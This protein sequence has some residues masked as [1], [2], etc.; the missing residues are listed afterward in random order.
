MQGRQEDVQV[1]SGLSLPHA[2]L[3]LRRP[4][5]CLAAPKKRKLCMGSCKV[6][7]DHIELEH[8][9]CRDGILYFKKHGYGADASWQSHAGE[10]AHVDC[11]EVI[12]LIVSIHVVHYLSI[13]ST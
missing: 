13:L 10:H 3:W 12:I 4:P 11:P 1:Q 5:L 8:I 2:W 6:V 7:W 9:M